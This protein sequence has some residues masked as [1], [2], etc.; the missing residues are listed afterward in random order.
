VQLAFHRL[1]Q[2]LDV[3]IIHGQV[4]LNVHNGDLVSIER[5][6]EFT[7]VPVRKPL[8]TSPAIDA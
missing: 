5:I 2:A 6:R 7:K 4:I 3:S 1:Q 8:D